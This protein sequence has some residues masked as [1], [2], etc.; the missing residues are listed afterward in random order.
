M[1]LISLLE[2]HAAEKITLGMSGSDVYFLP[3]LNAYLKIAPRNTFTDLQNEKN[4]LEWL[5]GKAA[6][7]ELLGY[8]ETLVADYMLTSAVMGTPLS[9]LLADE[10]SSPGSELALAAE[11]AT[12]LRLLHEIPIDQCPLDQRLDIKF[13]RAHKNIRFKLLSQTDDQFA[14]EHAGM[15]PIDVYRKL[16]ESQP[17]DHD[18]V[19]T[20]GDACMP[21]LIMRDGRC[22]GFVDLDGAGV[23]DRYTDIAVFFRSFEYNCKVRVDVRQTFIEAY[24]IDQLD[25]RKMKFFAL[26]DDLF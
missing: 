17:E 21:N 2:R 5:A 19:F 26:L 1:D 22:A 10:T 3:D 8:Q 4:A 15:K 6:V 14:A 7:P 13:A 9:D 23:A 16:L 25:I 11:A 24:G 20:H 18:L 12:R